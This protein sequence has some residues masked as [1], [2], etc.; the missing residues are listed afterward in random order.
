MSKGNYVFYFRDTL[1]PVEYNKKDI[2]RYAEIASRGG[3]NPI[4]GFVI[5]E[6]EH[7]KMEQF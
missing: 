4:N 6:L 1:N 3:R 5:I 7:K 2:L